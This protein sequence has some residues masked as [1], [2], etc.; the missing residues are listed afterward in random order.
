MKI[1]E[2][3]IDEINNLFNEY[4]IDEEIDFKLSNIENF[5]Y[6]VN[7]LVKHRSHNKIEEIVNKLALLLASHE[8]LE[9]FEITKNYFINIR[10]NL[11]DCD[12]F[13]SNIEENLATPE[14]K[15]ILI[16]YG[17][18]NIGKPL[19]V[20]H[21]RSLNIGRSLKELNKIIGHQVVTD[22]HLG[23]WGMPVAQIIAFCEL[24]N[25]DINSLT[26]EKLIDIYPKASALYSDS[27]DF[28]YLAKEKNKKLNNQ[29]RKALDQWSFL[30]EI[31][32]ESIKGTLSLLKHDFDLWLGESDVNELIEPMIKSLK[33]EGKVD[34]DDNALVSTE[35]SDPKILIAK[36]DGSYLYLTTDIATILNRIE[37]YDFDTTLY[38]VDARQKLHFIQLFQ[39]IEYFNFPKRE[40]K[41]LEFGTINDEKGKPFKTRDGGTKK[42]LAL[43]EETFD[44]IKN[45]NKNLDKNI[46]HKLTNTVLTYSDLLTNRKTDYKFD[47]KKFTNISGKTGIYVQYAQVRAKN[48]IKKSESENLSRKLNIKTEEERNLTVGLLNLELIINQS[49]KFNE[50]HH[51]ANYLYEISNLFN[52]F[53]QD[54]NILNLENEDLK[55][56]KLLLT[57]YFLDTT[58]LV[59]GCLGIEPVEEM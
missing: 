44:Y 25:I 4:D 8:L 13:L 45:I 30:K 50:P 59:F 37:N 7:N 48:I 54:E 49:I 36:S 51:L 42:L 29:E 16:D 11:N 26:A 58:K 31:S 23:D 39:T 19:H 46:I 43:Y 14:P 32:I 5:D 10:I 27:E 38:V 47:L 9:N 53:Y 15:R 20:G 6:Q 57:K 41:H 35:D 55:K 1:V 52:I 2:S 22:I 28:Q 12:K 3:L 17:G 33:K 18:P 56:S 40:Y 24:E 34:L 21:L